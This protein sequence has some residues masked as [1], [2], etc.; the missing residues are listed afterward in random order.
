MVDQPN[1]EE[2]DAYERLLGDAMEGDPT[3]F[4][5]EDAVEAAWAVVEPILGSPRRRCTS[6]SPAGGRRGRGARGGGRRMALAGARVGGS[7][8]GT[9]RLHDA[10]SIWLDNILLGLLG[11]GGLRAYGIATL[12]PERFV[13]LNPGVSP[14]AATPRSSRP[15]PVSGDATFISPIWSGSAAELLRIEVPDYRSR[16]LLL[17]TPERAQCGRLGG[18]HAERVRLSRQSVP[19]FHPSPNRPIEITQRPSASAPARG[20]K[21]PLLRRCAFRDDR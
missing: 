6:T 18:A 19:A 5:R 12:P 3:L 14:P 20:E 9:R 2:M 8:N 21:E 4:A 7:M 16:Q 1:G 10:E 17:C 13:V 11:S 15:A